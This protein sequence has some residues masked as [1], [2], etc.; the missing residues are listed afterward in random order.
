MSLR[1]KDIEAFESG[2]AIM[3]RK[4]AEN[5]VSMAN[6][7]HRNLKRRQSRTAAA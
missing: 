1:Y 5:I 6:Q 3:P 2:I 7:R 4:I